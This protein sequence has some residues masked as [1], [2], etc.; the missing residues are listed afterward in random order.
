METNTPTR[1]NMVES[2]QAQ[3]PVSAVTRVEPAVLQAEV[4][5]AAVE[6]EKPYAANVESTTSN[7]M[8]R[9]KNKKDD[10]VT[11]FFHKVRQVLHRVNPSHDRRKDDEGAD[12]AEY[13]ST[14]RDVEVPQ[15]GQAPEASRSH[16][17]KFGRTLSLMFTRALDDRER[18]SLRSQA[19]HSGAADTASSA[20]REEIKANVP[21]TLTPLAET[22]AAPTPA[23]ATEAEAPASPPHFAEVEVLGVDSVRT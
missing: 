20:A 2:L 13:A 17:F 6:G 16:R 10:K 1:D 4:P 9:D 5:G 8:S 3:A 22:E 18:P 21:A 23:P 11:P 12:R 7:I 14:S 15:G 19:R